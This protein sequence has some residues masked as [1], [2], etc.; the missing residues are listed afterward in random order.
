MSR[1]VDANNS[2]SESFSSLLDRLT[3][4]GRQISEDPNSASGF[5]RDQESPSSSDFASGFNSDFDSAFGS[6][7][8]SGSSSH[9]GSLA[10]SRARKRS[11]AGSIPVTEVK[12]RRGKNHSDSSVLSYENALRIHSRRN[13]ASDPVSDPISNPDAGPPEADTPHRIREFQPAAGRKGT[14]QQRVPNAAPPQA[15]AEDSRHVAA[16]AKPAHKSPKLSAKPPALG[17]IQRGVPSPSVQ[18]RPGQSRTQKQ[19]QVQAKTQA[20]TRAQA[21]TSAGDCKPPLPQLALQS[22]TASSSRSQGKASPPATHRKSQQKNGREQDGKGARASENLKLA[23]QHHKP[24][25]ENRRAVLSIR[26][27]DQES[28]QLRLRAAESGLSV[29]AYM[30][31]CVLDA[32]HLRS[33]VKKA[34]AEMRAFT[35]KTEQAQPSALATLPGGRNEQYEQS[36]S[37]EPWAWSRL[38]AKSAAAL[39]GLWLPIRRGI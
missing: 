32:E 6:D 10:S 8:Y 35:E 21:R 11:A 1:T 5:A 7:H 16:E 38:L 19:T 18:S 31:S 14:A 28:D 25:L 36:A 15:P 17:S 2:A 39:L 22:K 24:Q 30:R 3:R 37:A 27:S 33:Q 29:S 13:R 34:L 20:K 9:T 12:P 26:L 23:L 4:R